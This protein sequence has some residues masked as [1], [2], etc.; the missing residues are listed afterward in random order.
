MADP[1]YNPAAPQPAGAPPK[2]SGALK[3]I[4]I[5]LGVFVVLIMLVIGVIGFGV[6][7]VARAVHKNPNGTVSINVPGGGSISAGANGQ[8]TEAQLGIA[9]YPGA[10]QQKD[11]L[12]MSIGGKTMITANFLTP[13]P[14]DQ[15][16]AF[17]KDKAGPSAQTMSTSDM[18]QFIV[19]DGTGDQTTVM[20]TQNANA[21]N[22]ETSITIIRAPKGH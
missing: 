21:H 6:W 15:V 3:I 9:I 8:F 5:I 20:I 10:Q 14:K 18:A 19:D 12:Q 13:D 4:L 1:T 16:I 11:S 7:R 2:K 17:Y 22:G